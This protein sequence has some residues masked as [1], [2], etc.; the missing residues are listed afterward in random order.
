MYDIGRSPTKREGIA[1]HADDRFSFVIVI[2]VYINT[3]L[4]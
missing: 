2:V 1:V 4:I 3:V